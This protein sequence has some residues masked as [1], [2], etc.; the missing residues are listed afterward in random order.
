MRRSWFP[1]AVSNITDTG[2]TFGY[3]LEVDWDGNGRFFT[4]LSDISAYTMAVSTYRGRNFASQLTGRAQA[5]TLRATLNNEDG[6]FSSFLTSGPL[7]NK[8]LPNRK[9]RLRTKFPQYVLWTGF[10]DRIEPNV[11]SGGFVS[12]TLYASGSF[13][14][15]AGQN[16]RVSPPSQAETYT[17]PIISAILD[18]AGWDS[19][20][21]V[22]AGSVYVSRWFIEERDALA[23]LQEIEDTE[24]GFLYEGLAWDIGFEGRYSRFINHSTSEVTYSDATADTYH[25]ESIQ[26]SDPLREIYNR[27]EATVQPYE[28]EAAAVLWTLT[29]ASAVLA[30]GQSR[31]YIATVGSLDG[32]SV[33]YVSEWTTPVVG[34]DLTQTG[35]SDSNIAVSVVKNART[36][37]I[38]VTNNHASAAATL[39]LLQARGAAVLRLDPYK[40]SDEDTASQAKYGR[41]TYPLASPWYGNLPYAT[42]SAE[43]LLEIA[44][45]PRP[46][47][48]LG[49]TATKDSTHRLE[50]LRRKISDRVT[51][52]ATGNATLGVNQDFYIEGIGH[53]ITS[54]PLHKVSFILSPVVDVYDGNTLFI[55]GSSLVDGDHVVTH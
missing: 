40:I 4:E 23:S 27:F 13:I 31:T 19:S 11:G 15:L 5:G 48:S 37:E 16:S 2:S 21:I 32:V 30:A 26:Q 12:A 42:L 7:Y 33:A 34:T 24:F 45:E 52:K 35:V 9:V 18:A 54:G 41:R 8:I 50:A 55:V 22:E 6:R 44:T 47:F 1:R 20:R 14:K 25:Y 38:T 10:L 43:Y 49:W 28:D 51:V 46:L 53:D 17:G 39:T 29:G 36:M 3:V